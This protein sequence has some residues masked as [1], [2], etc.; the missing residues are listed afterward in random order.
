MKSEIP[1]ILKSFNIFNNKFND[2]QIVE[3]SGVYLFDAPIFDLR[4]G[5]NSLYN[6]FDS[7]VYCNRELN[8]VLPIPIVWVRCS[9]T[10]LTQYNMNKITINRVI[11]ALNSFTMLYKK[12]ILLIPYT[13]NSKDFNDRSMGIA[14]SIS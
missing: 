10:I 4:L 7:W 14:V 12:T 9:R 3:L 8:V 11:K 6:Y 2:V 1:N 5:N 13:I